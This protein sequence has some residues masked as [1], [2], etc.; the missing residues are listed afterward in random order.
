MTTV[1]MIIYDLD[2]TLVDTRKDLTASTNFALT[3]LGL[4]PR[5][6]AEVQAMVGDGAAML[7]KRAVGEAHPELFEKALALF[8]EHYRNNVCVYTTLYPSVKEV[9]A[10]FSGK[11]Q[12][13]FTNKPVDMAE[14][15]IKKLQIAGYFRKVLGGNMGLA[16]KPSPDGILL[17]CREFGIEPNEAVMVGDSLTDIQAGQA[18]GAKTAAVTYGYRQKSQLEAACPDFWIDHP[19]DL[20]KLLK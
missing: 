5:T 11:V 9:L 14:L 18:A 13:I 6:L 20:I 4:P 3:Q 17:L 12:T 1:K 7:M 2:G 15:L 10:H 19:S 16:L 8:R